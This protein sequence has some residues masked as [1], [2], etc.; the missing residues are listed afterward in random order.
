MTTEGKGSVLKTALGLEN[1]KGLGDTLKQIKE[2]KESLDEAQKT[3]SELAK[4]SSP[5]GKALAQLIEAQGLRALSEG[6]VTALQ[7]GTRK[8]EEKAETREKRIETLEEENKELKEDRVIHEV[9]EKLTGELDRRL[10]KGG[11]GSNEGGESRLIKALEGVVTDYLGKRLAGAG[12]D[13]LSGDQIRAIIHEEVGKLDGGQKNP[14]EMVEGLVNALTVGDKL[15]EKL[16][17]PGLGGRLLQGSQ[18][19]DSNLRTDL[20]KIL[21]E[22]QRETLKIE[23]EH[24]A[25]MEWNKHVGTLASTVKENLGTGIAA[26]QAAA[27]EFKA[28]AGAK[29]P[30]SE[31]QQQGFACS[32][33]TQFGTPAGWAGQ[34][35][36]CPG[37]GR[38]YTKQELLG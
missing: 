28:G 5:I 1:L 35:L 20:I 2:V 24:E 11:G 4:E 3:I 16:G 13:T 7:E 31:P 12:G 26:I 6:N 17:M 25:K 38:E 8:M 15:R 33:G 14:E 10:P 23:R 32:C 29:P 27:A 22:D 37:C 34:P 30:A 36:K 21:L 19:G 9:T 18:G